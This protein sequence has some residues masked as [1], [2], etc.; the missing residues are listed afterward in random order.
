MSREFIH[1]EGTNF[2]R[3]W[4]T[5]V[6]V[7]GQKVSTFAGYRVSG[8]GFLRYEYYVS[9]ARGIGVWVLGFALPQI[10]YCYSESEPSSVSV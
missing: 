8:I 9:E 4:D 3:Y 1:L 5:R 2:Q 6:L 10:H 7:F